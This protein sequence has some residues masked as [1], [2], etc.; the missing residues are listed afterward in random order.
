[1]PEV[2]IV[3]AGQSGLQ[4]ALGLLE[5]GFGVSLF[6]SRSADEIA[7]GDVLSSQC[8]FESAL[9]SE[10]ALGLDYWRDD[11]PTIEGMSI[12]VHARDAPR[13]AFNWTAR[14]DWPAQSV[15][16]RLKIPAWMDAFVA[17][18]GELVI[19]EVTGED[20]ERAA[21]EHDLVV[22][23]SGKGALGDLFR[24]DAEK[25]PYGTPQ[26]ALALTYVNG[27]TP[28][29]AFSAI[30]LSLIPGVG[31]YFVFPALTTTG[32]CE[33][34]VFEGV[35]DGPLDCWGDVSTPAHISPGRARFS[36]TSFLTR[37]NGAAISN[38][39]TQMG[40]SP[41]GL[42]QPSGTPL[43]SC[44]PVPWCWAW[45]MLSSSTTRSPARARTT[46][47]SVRRSTWQ[48]SLRKATTS[49]NSSC[50]ARSTGTGAATRSGSSRGRTR[51]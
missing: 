21:R 50:S 39:P 13:E 28:L 37:R 34:M 22:V 26:R 11:C 30:R 49:I 44:P 47:R 3:G 2:A 8:M 4:L 46:P 5:R 32:P 24:R 42:Y 43:P 19:K 25:S 31:E 17:R 15:D 40:F 33:I 27:M 7:S 1:M 9:E 51:C 38:S 45:R 48:A 23:A 35:L 6:S 12:A 18:G 20:L 36:N 16:Q 14:L 29:P 41:V 10:R